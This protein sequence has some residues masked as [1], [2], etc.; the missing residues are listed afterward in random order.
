VWG[1]IVAGVTGAG[2]HFL[3]WAFLLI[4]SAGWTSSQLPRVLSVLYLVG[5]IVSLFV[6][7]LPDLEGLAGMLGIVIGMWTGF[8]LWRSGSAETQAAGSD[9]SLPE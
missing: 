5:G 4:G 2:W 9:A 6:Y 8:L 7:L 3:G 1:T